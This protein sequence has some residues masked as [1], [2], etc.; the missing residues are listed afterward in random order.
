MQ[1]ES[2]CS[3]SFSMVEQHINGWFDSGHGYLKSSPIND[4]FQQPEVV[5]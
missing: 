4:L 2:S 3:S 5:I 1:Q